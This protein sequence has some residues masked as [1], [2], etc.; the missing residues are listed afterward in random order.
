[1]VGAPWI[2]VGRN[3]VVRLVRV[4]TRRCP[5]G[6]GSQV[7]APSALVVLGGKQI[8]LK[9]DVHTQEIWG[10]GDA[11]SSAMFGLLRD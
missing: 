4:A 7:A 5:R 6:L 11:K 3:G 8:V 9:R 2:E 10:D 1:M